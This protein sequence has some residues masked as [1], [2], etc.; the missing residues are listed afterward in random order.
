M[1]NL[2]D[3]INIKQVEPEMPP[4]API[5]NLY[6]YPRNV[7]QQQVQPVQ[8]NQIQILKEK[9]EDD[10]RNLKVSFFVVRSLAGEEWII[11]TSTTYHNSRLITTTTR[12]FNPDWSSKRICRTRNA[13]LQS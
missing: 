11:D 10:G 1:S 12:Q 2:I 4:L 7:A 3:E 9:P 13:L 5:R 6:N 8:T